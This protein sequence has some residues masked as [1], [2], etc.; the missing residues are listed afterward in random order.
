MARKIYHVKQ[1]VNIGGSQKTSSF[2]L[3]MEASDVPA[4]LALL[5]GGIK[6]TEQND[7]LTDMSGVDTVVSSVNAVSKINMSVVDTD[8]DRLYETIAPYQGVI[9]MKNTIDSDALKTALATVTPFKN[10]TKKP[11]RVSANFIE[12]VPSAG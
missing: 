10:S 4:F 8:G 3:K 7:T 6:I 9:Y 2:T 12:D 5:E 1:S 11:S